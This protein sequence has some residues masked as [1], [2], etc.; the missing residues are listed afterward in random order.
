MVQK[1]TILSEN[2]IRDAENVINV[3]VEKNATEKRKAECMEAERKAWR[4]SPINFDFG[5]R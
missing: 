5:I 2:S 1:E 3:Q 4:T